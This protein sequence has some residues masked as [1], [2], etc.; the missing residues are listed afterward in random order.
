MSINLS[1]IQMIVK[2][3]QNQIVYLDMLRWKLLI[4]LPKE[5]SKV[6]LQITRKRSLNDKLNTFLLVS[7]LMWFTNFW[8][9]F[10]IS[11]CFYFA[12]CQRN[13]KFIGDVGGNRFPFFEMRLSTNL[14]FLKFRNGS[15]RYTWATHD[16][17]KSNIPL[18]EGL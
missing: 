11:S 12:L 5:L 16:L 18:E 13:K 14:N 17:Q 6:N 9:L 4:L 15:D 3:E 8:F 2:I 1:L 10:L 7:L